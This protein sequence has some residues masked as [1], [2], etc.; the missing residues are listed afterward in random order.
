MLKL[1]TIATICSLL[2][3]NVAH[4]ASYD[5]QLSS[6]EKRFVI[7]D[8]GIASANAGAKREMTCLALNVYFEARGTITKQQQGV[9]WVAKNRSSNSNYAGPN[10][11][12]VVFERHGGTAQFAWTS[13]QMRYKVEPDSWETAQQIAREV[14]YGSISDPT[15]GALCFHE[16]N[17]AARYRR[18]D[19]G[20]L[21]IGSH[22]FYNMTAK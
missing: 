4:A 11:C 22:V 8:T 20:G 18:Y 13:H 5:G 21:R 3:A 15:H 17:L 7:T 9:A 6:L 12:D 16:T 2:C 14:Y 10:L 19:H 1:R